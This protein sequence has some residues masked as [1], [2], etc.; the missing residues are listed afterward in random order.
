MWH[1]EN[2]TCNRN[3]NS[4]L[5]SP[6]K[7][8]LI[9]VKGKRILMYMENHLETLLQQELQSNEGSK[10]LCFLHTAQNQDILKIYPEYPAGMGIKNA[11]KINV[12]RQV[13]TFSSARKKLLKN[14]FLGNER[15]KE[16]Q[17][18]D[19]KQLGI[20]YLFCS[21]NPNQCVFVFLI[22]II[23]SACLGIF[24]SFMKI[25]G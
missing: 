7:K 2:I 25:C 6:I 14:C 9:N 21:V 10:K 24:F 22:W 5:D 12:D 8:L 17:K 23:V 18:I 20:A 16:T 13:C 1:V 11:W 4:R 15:R 19:K 3:E